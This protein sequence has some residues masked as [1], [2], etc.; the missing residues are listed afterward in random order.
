MN[1]STV[2]DPFALES[3][4]AFTPVEYVNSVAFSSPSSASTVSFSV[5]KRSCR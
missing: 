4:T 5:K 3:F 1:G 2:A